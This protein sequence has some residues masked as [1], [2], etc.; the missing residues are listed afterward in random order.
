M[1]I[2]FNIILLLST[3]YLYSQEKAKWI[4][5]LNGVDLESWIV[6]DPPVKVALKDSVLILKMTANTSRHAFLRTEKKYKNFIFEVDFRRDAAIDSGI[7]FRA[8]KAPD[9]AYSGLFGYMVKIDPS[10]TR[11]WT[12][13]LFTDYGNSYN[14][15]QSLEGN[16]E[17][18]HA[19]MP[20]G[21]WN[22]LRI[23]AIGKTIKVWLNSVPTA[24]I[25]DNKY[26]SGYL[27]FKIHFL[28]QSNAENEAMEIQFK[29][30]RIL[31]KNLNKNSWPINLS[32]I[33]TFNDTELKYFR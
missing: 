26:K 33:N 13:G 20:L 25:V 29:N 8:E 4:P 15:L 31:T 18:Q 14:W 22:K 10:L 32:S 27:G 7:I 12:G 28:K 23:E 5:L 16:E 30:P 1:K 11:C 6:V 24:H 19:E 2:F 3:F 21:K 17:G 9:S